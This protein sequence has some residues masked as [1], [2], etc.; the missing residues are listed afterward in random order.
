MFQL[1]QQ[2]LANPWYAG[3]LVFFTQILM[4]YF[5]TMNIFYTTQQNIFGSIWSNNANAI[6]WLMSM[7]IGMNSMING[8]VVPI[9]A[10][11]IGGSLGTYWGIKREQKHHK[12]N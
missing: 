6:A 1:F 7:T 10:Y 4:L 12:L 3:I 9:I 8:Q 5:R 2:L 11:L